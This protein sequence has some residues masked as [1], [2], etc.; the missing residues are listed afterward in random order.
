M[1][2]V[3]LL[4]GWTNFRLVRSGSNRCRG[5]LTGVLLWLNIRS[6]PHN[7]FPLTS[8][9]LLPM[10]GL[11]SMTSFVIRATLNL[12]VRLLNSVRHRLVTSPVPTCRRVLLRWSLF[13]VLTSVCRK[14]RGPSIVS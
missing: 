3:W 13:R 7:G 14:G 10:S 2:T 12:W 4:S 6:A 11:G 5:R 9:V 1:P 8:R